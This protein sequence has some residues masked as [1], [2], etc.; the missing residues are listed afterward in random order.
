[1][2]LV[3]SCGYESNLIFPADVDG[4]IHEDSL[5]FLCQSRRGVGLV[6]SLC[7]T[8]ITHTD[9]ESGKVKLHVFIRD[10]LVSDSSC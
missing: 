1:M 7:M 3:I 9:A 2:G 10:S 4:L 6:S 5:A 8:A